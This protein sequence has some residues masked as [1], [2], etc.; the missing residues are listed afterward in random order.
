MTPTHSRRLM[1]QAAHSRKRP[2]DGA[3][4]A[5]PAAGGGGAKKFVRA[6]AAPLPRATTDKKVH[7]E[8][9]ASARHAARAASAAATAE[10][11]LDGSAGLLEAEGPMERTY[12][13]TQAALVREVGAGAA[14]KSADFGLDFGPYKCAF[15]RNGRHMLVGG[16]KGHLAVMDWNKMSLSAELN[17]GERVHDVTF[18]HNSSLFAAAQ[19]RFVHIYDHT[20]A[21][22]HVMR[23]HQEPLALEFLPHHFLL[24]S[25]GSAGYLK[26]QDVSTGSLVA[27]HRTRLGACSVLRQNP[28][29]AVLCAGHA[30]GAVTM[31]TPNMSVPVAKLSAHR[32]P[33]TALAC[34]AGGRYLVTAGG[35]ARL[36]V[37]DVRRWQEVHDYF[38]PVPAHA[39]DVSQRGLVAVG[40]G[41]HVQIWGRD[42][43]LE[44]AR[45]SLHAAPGAAG[46][47][48][49]EAG[50]GPME[51]R[52]AAAAAAGVAKAASPYMRHE[53][54]GRAVTS[55]RFRPYDDLCAVA[56]SGGVRTL[57]VPGAGEPNYDSL[58]ADPFEGKKARQ[59]AEVHALL[60][61]IP[62]S[63]ISLDPSKVAT[64]D[65]APK[66]VKEKE[67]RENTAAAAE[68]AAERLLEVRGKKRRGI[69]KLLKRAA[70]VVTEQRLALE[71]KVKERKEEERQKATAAAAGGGGEEQRSKGALTRLY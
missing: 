66:A 43:G 55:V 40:Y 47:G 51:L 4:A 68:K 63:M 61:K 53:L 45:G 49:G 29:N 31:W 34:D 50:A 58:A 14:K 52:A 3:A 5:A 35:D 64:L 2:R 44:G 67:A 24:A 10:I 22:V 19:R 26:Y 48:A 12:K 46:G 36:K 28:W 41:S 69:R 70:N 37:W 16:T 1:E 32:A 20:G 60:D 8:H 57:L 17:V 65:T 23:G 39:L 15:T 54:P 13:L 7:R 71:A 25:V 6:A 42:F 38:T 18:L 21:E 62:A 9:K 59:E 27:E 56:H 30:S 11:L 33:V